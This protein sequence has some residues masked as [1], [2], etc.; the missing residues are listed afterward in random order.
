MAQ[1]GRANTAVFLVAADSHLARRMLHI[2]C[3]GSGSPAMEN[4]QTARY[5][6]LQALASQSKIT[7]S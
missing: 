2:L 1:E 7:I 6:K 4:L 3:S 5:E